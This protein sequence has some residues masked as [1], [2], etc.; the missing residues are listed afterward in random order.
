MLWGKE[1]KVVAEV[2]DFLAETMRERAA[3]ELP[4][5]NLERW[6][7]TLNPNG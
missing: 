2:L 7:S 4:Q 1:P 6:E 3:A 5:V